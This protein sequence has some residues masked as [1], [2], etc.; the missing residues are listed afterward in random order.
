MSEKKLIDIC[1]NLTKIPPGMRRCIGISAINLLNSGIM[2]NDSK[3]CAT[4]ARRIYKKSDARGMW[5]KVQSEARLYLR[6]AEAHGL[7]LERPYLIRDRM[8]FG[9]LCGGLVPI[10]GAGVGLRGPY[11]KLPG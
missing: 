2:A 10:C 5:R 11:K 1:A 7:T 4:E 3:A 8:V 6:I 9:L